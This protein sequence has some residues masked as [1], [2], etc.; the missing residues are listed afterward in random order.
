MLFNNRT[1]A[2]EVLAAALNDYAGQDNTLIL[3]L[4]RGGVPV[5]AEV[6]EA[7]D[8]PLDLLLVRK[9]GVPGQ[10][11][12]AM[13]ALAQGGHCFFNHDVIDELRLTSEEID[14]VIE[15]ETAELARRERLYRGDRGQPVVT[16]KT[17]ILVDDGLAT[18]ATMRVAVCALEQNG[19]ARIVVAVPVGAAE[20]CERFDTR[21]D[22][23][24]CPHRMSPLRGVGLWYDDF[25]QTSDAEVIELLATHQHGVTA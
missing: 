5:A 14:M 12:Y 10:E 8:L 13:G 19:A 4:P 9:L 3:A 20:S 24:V 1:H 17:V 18:G 6:A 2:G 15:R 16:G 11:E 22:Q 25:S 23:V 7:L 21:V